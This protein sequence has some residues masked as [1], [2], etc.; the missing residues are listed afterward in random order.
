[1]SIFFFFGSRRRLSGLSARKDLRKENRETKKK[2]GSSLILQHVFSRTRWRISG[3][4][5]KKRRQ[6]NRKNR[7]RKGPPL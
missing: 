7:K 6:K 2:G 4:S 1:M 3:L 5:R